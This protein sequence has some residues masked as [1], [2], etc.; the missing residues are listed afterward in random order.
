MHLRA[1]CPSLEDFIFLAVPSSRIKAAEPKLIL[2]LVS[3][4]T[5]PRVLFPNETVLRPSFGMSLPK[6]APRGV[7]LFFS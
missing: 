4:Y 3:M 6:V 7:N 2:G 1:C 5:P